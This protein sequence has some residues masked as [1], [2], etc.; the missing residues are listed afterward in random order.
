MIASVLAA[1]MSTCS[2]LLVDSGAL[3]TEGLYRRRLVPNR[4]DHHYLWVGRLSGLAI[5]SSGSST[6]LFLI[7]SVLYTFL[8]TETMATFVGISLLG[9]IVWRRANRWGALASS[10]PRSSR[11]SPS[12]TRSGNPSTTGIRMC[13]SPRFS[14]ASPPWSSSAC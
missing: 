13:S 9:G 5:S 4:P 6:P 8:L 3:F 2:A 12:T 11:I 7:K 14:S 1:N 10:P